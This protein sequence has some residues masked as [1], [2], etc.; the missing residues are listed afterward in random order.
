MLGRRLKKMEA[1]YVSKW[2]VVF[3]NCEF[4]VVAASLLEAKQEVQKQ[5][6]VHGLRRGQKFEIYRLGGA[7]AYGT[8]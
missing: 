1:V 6:P 2:L 3:S 8:I 5:I 7:A 4:V